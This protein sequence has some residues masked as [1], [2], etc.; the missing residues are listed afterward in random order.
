MQKVVPGRPKMSFSV[1]SSVGNGT[2]FIPFRDLVAQPG[3]TN[4][5]F[6][7][8]AIV[9]RYY[10]KT[11]YQVLHDRKTHFGS[12]WYNVF[13]FWRKY[14][15]ESKSCTT[16]AEIEKKKNLDKMLEL[17]WYSGALLNYIRN[18]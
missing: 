10:Q 2:A 3:N 1:F 6:S 8:D 12:T 11:R 7:N 5:R 16:L 13:H 18:N 17:I 15:R 9:T 14:L 4:D